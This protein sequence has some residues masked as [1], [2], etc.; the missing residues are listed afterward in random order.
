MSSAAAIYSVVLVMGRSIRVARIAGIPVGVSP[1]WLVI[2][3]ALTWILGAEYFPQEVP[4]LSPVAA[5]ALGLASVLLLFASIL[6][7]EFGHALV[8]RA[9]GIEVEEIDLWLLGGV[10]KMR[11]EAKDP[12]VELRYALAGPAVSA[13]VTACFALLDV[14]LPAQTAATGL[15]L[16][17][18]ELL[19]NGLILGFNLIPAF[20]LDGGRVLRALL[21][22]RTGRIDRA[23]ELAA[24]VGRFCGYVLIGLGIV[25]LFSAYAL[26]GIWF[27][28]I[29]YFIITAAREEALGVEVRTAFSGVSA[30]EIMSQP[31]IVI[32]VGEDAQR[33]LRDYFSRFRYS[34]FPVADDSGR[35]LG[36]L[37]IESLESLPAHTLRERTLAELID[38]DPALL[39]SP[40]TD[41]SSILSRPAFRR[42][43]RAV[44]VDEHSAALGL[45]SVTDI[46]R[47]LRAQ[48]VRAGTP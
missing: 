10:S 7:H 11:G 16:I 6:A 27:A 12:R 13:L 2:V 40:E 45:V 47:V 32:P 24:S 35:V 29:G 31:V 43:G 4:G 34:A 8:A 37:T 33:A 41:I 1:W 18:Y 38:R 30:G 14:L 23:T 21:W 22:R 3:A 5:Y 46:E 25:A 39:V 26:D 48:R 42:L 9:N 20:P 17:R 19:I 44:V 36:L 28:L 15:A